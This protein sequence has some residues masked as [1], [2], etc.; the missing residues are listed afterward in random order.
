M[1]GLLSQNI[2]CG[3]L[4]S[5]SCSHGAAR[6]VQLGL[7]SALAGVLHGC[8]LAM[9][10]ALYIKEHEG[11]TVAWG[12]CCGGAINGEPV[13]DSDLREVRSADTA[14]D[15][16]LW[17]VG[18]DKVKRDHGQDMLAEMHEDAVD[19]EAMEP[20]GE[21]GLSTEEA[22]L[23]MEL[24]EDF[25]GEIFCQGEVLDH[26]HADGEDS[27]LVEVIELCKGVVVTA[28]RL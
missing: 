7:G 5:E 25:L 12:Q 28:L 26:A 13:N 18:H 27:L 11:V 23:A 19:G 1:T 6:L 4:G 17:E 16:L 24:E 2:L 14:D 3:D 8:N 21:G 10:K 15:V 22:E 9:V 20:G